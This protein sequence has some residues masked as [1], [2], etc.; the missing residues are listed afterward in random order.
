MQGDR[1]ETLA[2]PGVAIDGLVCKKII[3]IVKKIFCWL[4]THIFLSYHGIKAEIKIT[5]EYHIRI[6][7]PI[8]VI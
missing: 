3:S 8:G 1:K 2:E 4:Y 5:F 6:K 7:R